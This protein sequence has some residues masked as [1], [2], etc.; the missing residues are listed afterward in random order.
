M[1]ETG[2]HGRKRRNYYPSTYQWIPSE[3]VLIVKWHYSNLDT[4][5]SSNHNPN[6]EK[7][8]LSELAPPLFVRPAEVYYWCLQFHSYLHS[9][10]LISVI[11]YSNLDDCTIMLITIS[12]LNLRVSVERNVKFTAY[13][14]TVR[15]STLLPANRLHC[16]PSPWSSSTCLFDHHRTSKPLHKKHP[17]CT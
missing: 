2:F 16:H 7:Y 9:K 1:A 11:Q 17:S 3:P 5:S 12:Q 13:T 6:R 4:V 8:I 15:T 10:P 14:T